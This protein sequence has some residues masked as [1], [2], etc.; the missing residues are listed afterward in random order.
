MAYDSYSV[1]LAQLWRQLGI[2]KTAAGIVFDNS[3]PLAKIRQA[4]ETGQ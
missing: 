4:I 3:A 1:D 2:K